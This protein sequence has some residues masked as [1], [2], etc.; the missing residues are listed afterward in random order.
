MSNIDNDNIK[1][2]QNLINILVCIAMDIVD[3]ECLAMS[4][5]CR[6]V[7]FIYHS[8]QDKQEEED[9]DTGFDSFHDEELDVLLLSLIEDIKELGITIMEELMEE[10]LE[11]LQKTMDRLVDAM[12]Q[13]LLTYSKRIIFVIIVRVIPAWISILRTVSIEAVKSGQHKNILKIILLLLSVSQTILV[14]LL[15]GFS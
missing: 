4:H 8:F 15:R 6:L 10:L 2:L 11:M 9:D 14:K 7:D 3:I 12:V 5:I 13:V 1:N